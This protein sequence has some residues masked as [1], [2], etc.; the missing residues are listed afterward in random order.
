LRREREGRGG[1]GWEEKER[2]ERE[3]ER[4]NEVGLGRRKTPSACPGL[5]ENVFGSK[6]C[7]K[8]GG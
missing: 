8:N 4:E 6:K 5:T 7:P 3:S 1:G 2:R